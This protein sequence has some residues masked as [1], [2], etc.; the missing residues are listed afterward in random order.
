MQHPLACPMMNTACSTQDL[1]TANGIAIG[2]ARHREGTIW[3]TCIFWLTDKNDD[4]EIN[5]VR[6]PVWPRLV[7]WNGFTSCIRYKALVRCLH[8]N[9][10]LASFG[11]LQQKQDR[12]TFR[13]KES[14]RKSQIEKKDE[15]EQT[16]HI[17]ITPNCDTTHLVW[18]CHCSRD[19]DPSAVQ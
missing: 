13:M 16:C 18:P 9:L 12:K 6:I 19:V 4:D 2:C 7:E 11:F 15:E 14:M 3:R 5:G 17:G 8:N 1:T 10:C